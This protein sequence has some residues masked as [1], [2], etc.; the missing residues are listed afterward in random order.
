[1]AFNVIPKFAHPS[2]GSANRLKVNGYR[3]LGA[4]NEDS[5]G[6]AI[7]RWAETRIPRSDFIFNNSLSAATVSPPAPFS[8]TG[9]FQHGANPHG[10]NG[11]NA[12]M[13]SLSVSLP[14]LGAV[15]LAGS[16]FKSRLERY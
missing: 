10:A 12:W 6:L 13:G 8:G 14:G 15:S 1:M 2:L 7:F 3:A 9:S 16:N 11:L 4:T 5:A